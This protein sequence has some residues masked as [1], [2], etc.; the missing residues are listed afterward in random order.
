[1][2]RELICIICPRG[3]RLTVEG[4]GDALAVAGNACPKGHTYAVDECT[5][6]TRTV[7]SIIRVANRPD[8]MVSVKTVHP[9]AKERIFEAMALIRAVRVDAPVAI[10]DV[11]LH[12]VC[13]T[14]I[15]ATKDIE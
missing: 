14:D 5:H 2:N 12:D 9:I 3:C 8:T 1:M 13:G 10:G 6:P 15:V 11:V 4:E 7:T